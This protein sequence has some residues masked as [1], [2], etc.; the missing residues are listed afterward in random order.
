MFYRLLQPALFA[1]DPETAHGLS[2]AGLKAMTALPPPAMSARLGVELAGLH[3]T[4]PLGVA[5]GYDKDADRS[6][7]N[8]R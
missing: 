7:R 2:L 5:A 3:F 8:I 4:N 1:L 6:T